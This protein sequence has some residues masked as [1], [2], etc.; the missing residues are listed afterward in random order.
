MIDLGGRELIMML[1]VKSG[2]KAFIERLSRRRNA[3]RFKLYFV[4][5]L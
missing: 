3:S 4:P 5:H 2:N 1:L